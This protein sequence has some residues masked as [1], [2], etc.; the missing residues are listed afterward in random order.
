MSLLLNPAGTV[1]LNDDA[2]EDLS[3]NDNDDFNFKVD[4]AARNLGG[5]EGTRNARPFRTSFFSKRNV[6]ASP[7]NSTATA[8]W[9]PHRASAKPIDTMT[10]DC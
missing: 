2:T 3:G 5:R 4:P 8:G 6:R 9:H 7:A 10:A 1:Q